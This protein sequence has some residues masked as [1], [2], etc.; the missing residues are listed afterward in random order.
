MKHKLA[1]GLSIATVTVVGLYIYTTGDRD[2]KPVEPDGTGEGLWGSRM[3][4][5]S[6][7][8]RLNPFA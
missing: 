5:L 2:P 3:N 8:R 6:G 4:R 1:L 7:G